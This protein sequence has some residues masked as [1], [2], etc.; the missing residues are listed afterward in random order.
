MAKLNYGKR[1]SQH[2]AGGPYKFDESLD[3]DMREVATHMA[4]IWQNL[5]KYRKDIVYHERKVRQRKKKELL[6]HE[7][8]E[9]ELRMIEAVHKCV[10]MLEFHMVAMMEHQPVPGERQLINQIGVH[11]AIHQL[12][13]KCGVGVKFNGE[14]EYDHVKHVDKDLQRKMSR[15]EERDE[16]AEMIAA[17]I[18]D[19]KAARDRRYREVADRLIARAKR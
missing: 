17:G 6:D 8:H 12:R 10:E 13:H 2:G 16:R 5:P 11:N 9:A 18:R 4:A 7:R 19:Q 1:F 14:S 3:R 15:E